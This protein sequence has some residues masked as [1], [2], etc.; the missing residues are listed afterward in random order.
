MKIG[1]VNLPENFKNSV[2]SINGVELDFVEDSNSEKLLGKT[3]KTIKDTEIVI[4]DISDF[5][6]ESGYIITKAIEQKK[7]VIAVAKDGSPV[8]TISEGKITSKFIDFVSYTDDK[9]F[10]KKIKN[11]IKQAKKKLDTKFILIISSVIDR[12]LEWSSNEKRMHKAQVVRTALDQMMARDKDWKNH[13]N[14]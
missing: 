8:N 14:S 11:S 9:D 13:I 12:Y 5:T 2:T 10:A 1:L 3:N 4:V 7:V 6:F